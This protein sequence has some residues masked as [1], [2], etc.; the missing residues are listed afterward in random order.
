MIPLRDHLKRKQT[1]L[2]DTSSSWRIF[3]K[4]FRDSLLAKSRMIEIDPYKERIYRYRLRDLL[5][6]HKLPVDI[7]WIIIWLNNIDTENNFKKLTHVY[8]PDYN[9][10]QRIRNLYDANLTT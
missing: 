10:I 3:L 5:Y 4:D 6:E 1:A 2:N 7:T 9:E 8:I